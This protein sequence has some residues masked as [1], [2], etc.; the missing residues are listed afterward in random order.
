MS[1]FNSSGTELFT[2]YG[3]NGIELDN[4]Y[5]IDGL[6]V[7]N[8]NIDYNSFTETL[9]YNLKIGTQGCTVYGD[10]IFQVI[11]N[12]EKMN[13]YRLSDGVSV[14]ADIGGTWG[15]GD[16]LSFSNEY[17]DEN[18]PFPLLYSTAN[19]PNLIYVNRISSKWSA[20]LVRTLYFDISVVGYY[21]A[22]V[23]DKENNVLYTTGYTNDNYLTD[24][25]GANKFICCKYV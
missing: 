6:E 8:Q 16:S 13:I 12:T 24:D 5:D 14:S 18:D 21:V 23:V 25:G 20:S 7:F 1:I 19:T 2:A 15:H 10:Y 3:K 11:A 17:Y 22:G 9:L 4:A